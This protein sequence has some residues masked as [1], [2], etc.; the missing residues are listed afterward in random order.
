MTF[1]LKEKIIERMALKNLSIAELER[2]AGL[3]IHSV[4][5]ILKDR[6]KK[7]NVHSLQA[8]AEALDCSLM[9]LVSPSTAPHNTATRD[10]QFPHR[11]TKIS[12]PVK[13]P[14][15]MLACTKTALDLMVEHD[16]KTSVDDFMDIVRK[17][18]TYSSKGNSQTVDVRFAE[19]LIET[20]LGYSRAI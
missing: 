6:I 9:D 16:L 13:F 10:I 14:D 17:V 4:R 7:P 19:W 20:Q 3:T 1:A 12:P 2:R 5:N 11:K 8:I 15:L 18:Y